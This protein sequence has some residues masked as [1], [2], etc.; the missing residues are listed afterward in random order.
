MLNAQHSISSEVE[1]GRY[2]LPLEPLIIR[3]PYSPNQQKANIESRVSSEIIMSTTTTPTKHA[4][5]LGASKGTGYHTLLNLLTPTS[6]WSA[7]LLLRKPEV[8]ETDSHFKEYLEGG[9]L[10]IV[11]GDATSYDDVK[12]LFVEGG[13]K[14][15]VV[16]SSVGMSPFL[17]PS[18]SGPH[19][20]YHLPRAPSHLCERI[21]PVIQYQVKH[22][23]HPDT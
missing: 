16:I 13:K 9:R 2:R 21:I 10:R 11:K 17:T 7:T 5:L 4:V 15:D 18:S 1:P 8:I 20:S 22:R 3:P 14:V 6:G 19:S 23:P 12:R